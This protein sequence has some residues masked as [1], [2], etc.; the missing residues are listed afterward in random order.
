MVSKTLAY[1]ALGV[2][3]FLQTNSVK[4]RRNRK[5]VHLNIC[6]TVN[7]SVLYNIYLNVKVYHEVLDPVAELINKQQ[8]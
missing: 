4:K 8:R 1:C 3:I 5:K 7:N 6:H 2:K